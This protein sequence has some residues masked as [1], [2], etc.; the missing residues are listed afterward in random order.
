MDSFSYLISWLH[1]HSWAGLQPV[2][3]LWLQYRQVKMR[4][5]WCWERLKAKGEGSS[6]GWDGWIA[7]LTQWTRIWADSDWWW[8]TEEPGVLQSMGSQSQTG[9]SDWTTPKMGEGAGP[10]PD[11]LP[12]VAEKLGWEGTLSE[13]QVKPWPGMWGSRDPTRE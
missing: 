7:S 3:Y 6:R 8:R 9:L 2:W 5:P 13:R 12:R 1:H 10:E 11:L 4:G